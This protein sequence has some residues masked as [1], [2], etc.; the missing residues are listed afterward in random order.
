ME[1]FKSHFISPSAAGKVR[2]PRVLAPIPGA[3]SNGRL[4]ATPPRAPKALPANR[5][6]VRQHDR[7]DRAMQR[8]S[9]VSASA[10]SQSKTPISRQEPQRRI[11]AVLWSPLSHRKSKE[12]SAAARTSPAHSASFW[13]ELE[14]CEM[15]NPAESPSRNRPTEGA[16]WFYRDNHEKEYHKLHSSF[17]LID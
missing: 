6:T 10:D 1:P 7:E 9:S 11:W 5:H 12:T 2:G 17:N 8:V 3:T 4:R 16:L 14:G 13:R 15:P